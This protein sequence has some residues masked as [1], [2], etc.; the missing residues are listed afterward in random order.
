MS[1]FKL[2]KWVIGGIIGLIY[3]IIGAILFRYVM[4]GALPIMY[5]F[6]VPILFSTSL[7]QSLFSNFSLVIINEI[8]SWT[9]LISYNAIFFGLIGSL[10]GLIFDNFNKIKRMFK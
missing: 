2:K 6:V 7:I 9:F 10:S 5:Y 8:Q 1:K 4:L 3:G